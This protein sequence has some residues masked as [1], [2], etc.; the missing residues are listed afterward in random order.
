MLDRL[1]IL[2]IAVA[3]ICERTRSED[4]AWGAAL[5]A[6]LS[7][8]RGGPLHMNF[9]HTAME[10]P[11]PPIRPNRLRRDRSGTNNRAINGAANAPP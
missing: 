3:A 7:T 10:A 4:L 8:P 2:L 9:L 11:L 5:V 1:R 6:N